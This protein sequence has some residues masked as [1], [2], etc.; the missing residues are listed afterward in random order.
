MFPAR[1][2]DP[3]L[4]CSM[5]RKRA[6]LSLAVI[7]LGLTA[8]STDRAP[9]SSLAAPPASRPAASTPSTA[10]ST[11]PSIAPIQTT[12]APSGSSATPRAFDLGYLPLWPFANFADAERWRALGDGHQPWHLDAEQTAL[13]FTSGYLGFTDFDRVTDTVIDP[14]GREAHVAVAYETPAARMIPPAVLHLVRFGTAADSPWEVVGS[15]DN[16]DLITIEQPV[17]G[18]TVSSPMTVGG[19]ITGVDESIRI[20]VRSLSSG[21]PLGGACCGTTGGTRQP[22]S[23]TFS[24]T[25]TGA[26]TI[27][28]STGGHFKGVESFAIQGVHTG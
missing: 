6:V 1:V 4:R 13:N 11:A 2:R 22:W 17:Y 23:E 9:I 10:P 26:L 7:G 3:N 20:T 14:G 19:Y 27:V 12:S 18:S 24:F 25:G 5:S 21:Q 28:A 16:P 8:C 15:D